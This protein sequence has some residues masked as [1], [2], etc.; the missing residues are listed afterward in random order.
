MSKG[1]FGRYPLVRI[2][3]QHFLQQIDGK[4]IGTAENVAKVA[5][6]RFRQRFYVMTGL[7]MY[8]KGS[9]QKVQFQKVT[10]NSIRLRR[11]KLKIVKESNM[12]EALPLRW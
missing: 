1:L 7:Q 8:G 10:L 3:L 11:R 12:F 4:R 9:T 5:L 2:Q 6:L